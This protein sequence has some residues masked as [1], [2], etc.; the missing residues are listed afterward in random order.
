M[1]FA[2]FHKMTEKGKTI[3]E[4][5]NVSVVLDMVFVNTSK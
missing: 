3:S 5:G 1:G 4:G 2:S